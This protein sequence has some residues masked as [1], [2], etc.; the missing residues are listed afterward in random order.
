[1]A[2]FAWPPHLPAQDSEP[3]LYS[4]APVGVNFLIAGCAHTEG[5]L[6][7]DSSL[8]ISGAL[9]RTSSGLLAYAR[10]LDLWGKSG[11]LDVVLPYSWLSGSAQ[12]AGEELRRADSPTPVRAP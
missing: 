7:F 3:R 6:T 2:W 8:P 12:F 11:K 1:M 10:V 4:N 9:L 5:A